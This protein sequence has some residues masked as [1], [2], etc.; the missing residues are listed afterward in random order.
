MA[1]D[2]DDEEADSGRRS[3]WAFSSFRRPLSPIA[4][5]EAK[6]ESAIPLAAPAAAAAIDEGGLVVGAGTARS[7]RGMRMRLPLLL[8]VLPLLRRGAAAP[9]VEEGGDGEGKGERRGLLLAAAAPGDCCCCC[10]WWLCAR[11][12]W[13]CRRTSCIEDGEEEEE[14]RG[15]RPAAWD[16]AGGG[17]EGKGEGVGEG[18]DRDL[19]VVVGRPRVPASSSLP[20][21]PPLPLFD[22]RTSAGRD[23]DREGGGGGEG[24]G[25]PPA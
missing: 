21:P 22:R 4:G 3:S 6:E 13:N 7:C 16:D 5:G 12:R 10:W 24:T 17:G 18:E 25:R 15:V 11:P 9:V 14:A 8:L 1:N 23:E 2:A 19:K 20:L